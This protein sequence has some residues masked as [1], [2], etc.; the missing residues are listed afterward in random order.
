MFKTD[1]KWMILHVRTACEAECLLKCQDVGFKIQT[2]YDQID[3]QMFEQI[4][5]NK[6]IRSINAKYSLDST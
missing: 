5:I 3:L 1:L 2:C 6:A 4:S